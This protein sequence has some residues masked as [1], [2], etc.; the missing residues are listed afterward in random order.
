M[1][2]TLKETAADTLALLEERVRRIDYALHGNHSS[3]STDDTLDNASSVKARLRHLERSLASLA[4]QSPT[5]AEVLALQKSHPSLFNLAGPANSNDIPPQQLVQI[6][7]SHAPIYTSLAS[8]LTQLSSNP[9]VPDNKHFV[10][11]VPLQDRIRK[12]RAREAELQQEVAMLRQ[13]SARVVKTWYEM[14]VLE[15]GGK[16]AEWEERCREAEKV[17]TKEEARKGREEGVV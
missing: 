15:M 5:V 12:A 11:I 17:L 4:A 2:S 10:Q 3:I 16:W 1:G 14:G 7:L 8:Q 13:R 6:I 9:S